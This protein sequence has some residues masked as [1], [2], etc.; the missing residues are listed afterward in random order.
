VWIAFDCVMASTTPLSSQT[1]NEK[2]L[3]HSNRTELGRQ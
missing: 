2:T 1:I 3:E